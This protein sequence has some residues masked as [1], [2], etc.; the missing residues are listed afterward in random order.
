MKKIIITV[1]TAV[2]VLGTAFVSYGAGYTDIKASNWACDA[3]NTMT[4][5]S[6][7]KGYPDGTFKPSNTVTYGEFIKMAVIA[8][9]GQDVGNASKPDHWALNYY[10][11]ALELNYFT[12]HEIDQSKLNSKITRGDM[13]LIISAILGDLTISNYDEIQTGIKDITYQTEHE[14]DITKAYAAG[15]LTGY[16]DKTFRPDGTLSRAESATVIYRLVDESKREVPG[17]EKEIQTGKFEDMVSNADSFVNPG[18]GTINED[19][20][21][22]ETYEIVTDGTKYGMELKENR[23]NNLDRDTNGICS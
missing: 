10:N 8:G 14:Y 2:M 6:I 15:I 5:K 7:V 9:A 21:A 22:A 4:D 23:R 3:V 17:G 20:A 1:I 11:K 16:T 18:N 19:L 12:E 13:A